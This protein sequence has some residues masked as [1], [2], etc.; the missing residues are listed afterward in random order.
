MKILFVCKNS[1]YAESSGVEV[2]I[3]NLLRCLAG[4]AEVTCI[5]L[6]EASTGPRHGCETIL[7]KAGVLSRVNKQVTRYTGHLQEVLI[8]PKSQKR[9][10]SEAIGRMTPDLIW[11][12]F[13][14]VCHLIPFLHQFG[15]PVYYGSHN[16][17]WKLDYEI[18]R[19]NASPIAWLKMAPFIALYWLQ[20]RFFMRLAD[21]F[22]CISTS[23]MEYYGRFIPRDKLRLLP[24]FFDCRHLHGVQPY[25]TDHPY[26]CLVGSLNSYQNFAAAI[27]ALEEIWPQI[28][29]SLRDLRLYI[30]GALP[31]ENSREYRL[32]MQKKRNDPTVVLTGRVDTVI[33]Y[34]KGA[35]VNIV[36]LT[37]GSGVRTKIIE[38]AACLVPV[39][40]T[41]IGAEGLPFENGKSIILADEPGEFA[42]QVIGLVKNAKRRR[43]LSECAYEAYRRELSFEAGTGAMGK[44]FAKERAE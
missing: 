12:E 34:V 37:L 5:F 33:P 22:F 42:E 38:S 1:P 25:A 14:Y 20:E 7:H 29:S 21:L 23:D 41:T 6:E 2:K 27:Y 32:L 31:Q 28:Q 10:L 24:F 18:W 15:I 16:S 44:L 8:A 35:L 11:L 39:V 4:I 43:D 13:G 26:I 36:P 40:S 9:R 19:A 17:Q 30:I 3:A